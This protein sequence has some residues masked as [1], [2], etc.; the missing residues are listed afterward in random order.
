MAYPIQPPFAPIVSAEPRRSNAHWRRPPNVVPVGSGRGGAATRLDRAT[1]T[2][3]SFTP[4]V[5]DDE[6]APAAT[7]ERCH[8]WTPE[9]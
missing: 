8:H 3:L 1:L 6:F 7:Y 4:Q 2:A 5:S 9:A